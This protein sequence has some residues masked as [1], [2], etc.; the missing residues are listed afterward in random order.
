MPRPE[1]LNELAEITGAMDATVARGVEAMQAAMYRDAVTQAA[2]LMMGL[3]RR[4]PIGDGYDI[5]MSARLYLEGEE[6]EGGTVAAWLAKESCGERDAPLERHYLEPRWNIK[7]EEITGVP[8]KITSRSHNRLSA[9]NCGNLPRCYNCGVII[10]RAQ[11]FHACSAQYVIP[12]PSGDVVQDYLYGGRTNAAIAKFCD[13]CCPVCI[14]GDINDSEQP[15]A[16]Y[17]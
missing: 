16:S 5:L 14:C 10:S 4:M 17:K 1:G 3:A 8:V 6:D 12:Q 15:H 11:Y 7:G 9:Q 2:N 13:A